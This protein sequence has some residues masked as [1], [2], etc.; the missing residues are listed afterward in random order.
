MNADAAV[1]N[2]DE[3]RSELEGFRSYYQKEIEPG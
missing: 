1:L 2:I 3:T